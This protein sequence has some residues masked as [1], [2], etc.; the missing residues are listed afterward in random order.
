[1]F[2]EG[3]GCYQ[4]LK[5]GQGNRSITSCLSLSD[6]TSQCDSV[7]AKRDEDKIAEIVSSHQRA[8]P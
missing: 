8:H 2:L 5:G 3:A 1:M 7:D 6:R 4:H